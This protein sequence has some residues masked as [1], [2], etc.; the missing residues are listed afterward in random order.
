VVAEDNETNLTLLVDILQTLGCRVSIARNGFE[1][2]RTV[3]V[4]PPDLILMDIQ[5]PG[6]DGL[7]ATRQLRAQPNFFTTPIIVLTA[8]AMPG[9]RDRCLAAGAN[10]YLT[11]PIDLDHL[12][13]AL[14]LFLNA[15]SNEP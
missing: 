3:Q 5:M 2:L 9:D 7:E 4:Y 6:M 8:L 12:T 15:G 11:K 10:H 13:A 14:K 1:V